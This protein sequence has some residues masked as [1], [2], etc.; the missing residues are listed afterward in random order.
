MAV[1]LVTNLEKPMPR[2]VIV[3]VTGAWIV[4]SSSA[5]TTPTTARTIG[6]SPRYCNPL[7]LMASSD[8]GSPPGVQLGDV[9]VLRDNDRYY[10]FCSGGGAW[11]SDDLEHG[12][13][14]ASAGKSR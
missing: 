10:M 4:Y 1:P 9:T 2:N 12:S 5:Q 6:Q 8:D 7:P 13:I 3:A 11:V 14:T